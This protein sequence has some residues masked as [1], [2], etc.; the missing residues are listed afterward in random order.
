VSKVAICF[1]GMPRLITET[2]LSW[3]KFISLYNADVFVHTWLIDPT[4]RNI[5]NEKI[6]NALNPKLLFAEEVKNF[7]TARYSERV[8]PHRSEPK[9]VLSMWYSIRETINLCFTYCKD[10]NIKYDIICRAR[11]DWW[12]D[13]LELYQNDNAITVPDDPGLNGHNFK[14][15]SLNYIGHN[16]QFGYGN[17]KMMAVYADTFNRIPWLYA[18][19]GVDFCSELLLTSNLIS[20]N[21]PVVYQK[22]LLYRILRS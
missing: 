6:V 15:N 22:N 14:Y 17:P 9:N 5:T 19:N 21:I 18:E 2:E 8:W 3:Q 10:T 20:N 11:M 1:A 12:C 4:K 16:D 13:N 7:N